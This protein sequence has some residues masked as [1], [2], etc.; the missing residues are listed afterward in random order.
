M[1]D[2]TL[3]SAPAGSTSPGDTAASSS[4]PVAAPEST[5]A[6]AA[7]ETAAEVFAEMQAA[8]SS[9]SPSDTTPNAP[10]PD[11]RA[12]RT[13][14]GSREATDSVLPAPRGFVP[15]DRHQAV[16]TRTRRETREE[17]ER[18]LKQKYGWAEAYKDPKEVEHAHAL[19]NWLH[20]DPDGLIAFIQQ[21]VARHAPPKPEPPPP[22]P[23]P[24]YETA[25]GQRF[26]TAEGLARRMEYERAQMDQAMSERLKPLGELQ[27]RIQL[28][29]L[30]Q[31]ASTEAASILQECRSTLPLFKELEPDIKALM[32]QRPEL[33]HNAA[34]NRVFAQKGATKMRESWEAERAGQLSRKA[35]A[36]SIN[37]SAPR[38]ATPRPDS[39]LSSRDIVVQEY[40]KRQMAMG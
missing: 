29:D 31:K 10:S 35:A 15:A 27:Q 28:A 19:Y 25:D 34:Y 33:D 13:P 36:S 8:A 21:Q 30:R 5:S 38:P 37:P 2:A 7:G 1:E 39:E 32:L 14:D 23:E 9:E 17:V 22:P 12:A 3:P 4:A 26:Y 20:R 16:V 11:A 40:R 18:E 6:P 24:D